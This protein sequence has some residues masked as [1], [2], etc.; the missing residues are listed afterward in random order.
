MATYTISNANSA[1]AATIYLSRG[2]TV[3][4]AANLAGMRLCIPAWNYANGAVL[5]GLGDAR[6][7]IIDGDAS[8]MEEITLKGTVTLEHIELDESLPVKLGSYK[9]ILNDCVINSY[10]TL[11]P[12]GSIEINKAVFTADEPIILS[13]W[14]GSTAGAITGIET[15]TFPE[16]ELNINI[17]GVSGDTMLTN[18]YTND[19]STTTYLIAYD[20]GHDVTLGAGVVLLS[21]WGDLGDL[22]GDTLKTFTGTLTGE[23]GSLLGGAIDLR[24]ATLK[25]VLTLA[26]GARAKVD[27]VTTGAT[28]ICRSGSALSMA[29]TVE[30]DA[31]LKCEAGFMLNQEVSVDALGTLHLAGAQVSAPI[32]LNVTTTLLV[33]EG[34]TFTGGAGIRLINWGGSTEQL[35]TQLS[36]VEAEAAPGITLCSYSNAT[37]AALPW[38]GAAYLQSG[39]QSGILT[40]AAGAILQGDGTSISGTLAGEAGS[41]LTGTIK[42]NATTLKGVL[43]LASGAGVSSSLNVSSGATFVCQAGGSLGAAATVDHGGVLELEPGF[44]LTQNVTVASDGLLKLAGAQVKSTIFL[45]PGAQIEL[46]AATSFSDS[47]AVA[48]IN[49]TGSTA[50]VCEQLAKLGQTPKLT[51][52]TAAGSTVLTTL[53]SGKATY[54]QGGVLNG[55]VT[56]TAGTTLLGNGSSI[57]ATLVGEA[58][59]VLAGTLALD[60]ATLLGTH[61]LDSG[62]TAGALRVGAGATVNARVGAALAS[63]ATVAQGGVLELESGFVLT[64]DVTVQSG[65]TLKL[66]GVQVKATIFLNSGAR[67]ELSAATSFSSTGAIA[68]TNWQGS[69]AELCA[70][71]A[72]LAQQPKLTLATATGSTTLATLPSGKVTYVQGGV[73]NGTVTLTA[74]ATLRGNGSNI[75][76]TLVGEEGSVLAGTLALG[77]ATLQGTHTLASGAKASTLRVVAGATVK[78]QAGAALASAARVENGGVLELE[79]G[80]V[81]TQDVT[82]QSGGTL[83]LEGVQVKATIFLTPDAGL[84]ISAG[85]SFTSTGAI[86]LT[87]WQGGTADVWEKLSGVSFAEGARMHVDSLSGNASLGELPAG[88]TDYVLNCD[89]EQGRTLTLEAGLTLDASGCTIAGTL[90]LRNNTKLVGDVTLTGTASIKA[91]N[92][93]ITHTLILEPGAKLSGSGLSF[94]C[95]TPLVFRNWQGDTADVWAGLSGLSFAGGARVH[96]DSL[97]GNAS[98]G[99]LPAG[100]TGYVLNCDLEQ[101]RT[102]TLEAGQ[103]LDASGG[104]IGGTLDCRAGSIL[105]GDITV[106]DGGVVRLDGTR[107]EGTLTLQPGARI[108]GSDG[109]IF[110]AATPIRLIDWQGDTAEAWSGLSNAVFQ[111]PDATIGIDSVKGDATLSPLPGLECLFKL[112]CDTTAL[113]S[114]DVGSTLLGTTTSF[115]SGVSLT[116]GWSDVNKQLFG[117]DANGNPDFG[118]DPVTGESMY[119][120]IAGASNMLAWWQSTYDTTQ[121]VSLTIPQTAADIYEAMTATWLNLA[122][123]TVFACWWWLTGEAIDVDVDL[124]GVSNQIRYDDQLNET[125]AKDINS[126]YGEYYQFAYDEMSVTEASQ[127]VFTIGVSQQEAV[128]IG[129]NMAKV[130]NSGGV[131]SLGVRWD[132]GATGHV[133]TLWGIGQREDGTLSTLYITDSDDVSTGIKAYK[134]KYV[135]ERLRYEMEGGAYT[136]AYIMSYVTLNAFEDTVNPLVDLS[137]STQATRGGVD[138]VWSSNE[139]T[140]YTLIID[141]E[142]QFTDSSATSYTATLTDGQHSYVFVATDA[143]GNETQKE[144]SFFVDCPPSTAPTVTQLAHQAGTKSGGETRV[145]FSWAAENASSYELTVDGGVVYSG[146][147]TSYSKYL[148]DGEHTYSLRAIGEDGEEGSRQGAD[149]S[150]D[151]TAPV[152]ELGHELIPSATPGMTTVIFSWTADE[153]CSYVLTVDGT[154]HHASDNSFELELPYGRHSY[155]IEA[156]DAFG[157]VSVES[158]RDF[159]LEAAAPTITKLTHQ[160]GTKSD[161]ETKVTFSWA[162]QDATRYEL[163]VDGV[164]VYRGA[165]SSFSKYLG[166]GEHSYSIKAIGEEDKS[167]ISEVTPFTTDA[168]AP[169]V[170]L[171]HELIPSATPG[172]TTV[173]FSWAADEPCSYVLTVDGTPH[174]VSDNSFELELPY[175]R[176]SYFVEATDAFGN[177][178]I[179]SGR[180]FTLEAA[181]LNV[182]KPAFKAAGKGKTKV[183]LSWEGEYG[184]DYTLWVDGKKVA[185]IRGNDK[186]REF[187]RT[188]TVKDGEHVYTIIAAGTGLERSGSFTTDATAPV[189]KLA[190]PTLIKAGEGLLAATFAWSGHEN[191]NVY[192]ITLDKD[193]KPT[194][195]GNDPS[196][197][198]TMADG[199]HSYKVT[200]TD[201]W[202][203]SSTVKGSFSFD[204]TAPTL[205]LNASKLK[206]AKNGSVAATLSW[207]GE[208]GCS[209]TLVLNGKEI[210]MQGKTSY[211]LTLAAGETM[212]YSVIARDKAG[213]ETVSETRTARLDTARPELGELGYSMTPEG[214]TTFIWKA[215]D[216]SGLTFSIKV[217]GK[218]AKDA[219]I[220]YDARTGLYSYTYSA[221]LKGG[222]HRYEVT[223]TDWAG[224]KATLKGADFVTPKLTLSKPKLSKAGEGEVH[225]LFSWKGD[226]NARYTLMVDSQAVEGGITEGKK[227]AYSYSGTFSDGTHSYRVTGVDAAG[228]YTVA[229]GSFSFD[230]TAPGIILGALFGEVDKKGKVKATLNWSGEDGVSYSIKLGKKSVYS[231]KGV[232]RSYTFETGTHTLSITAKDKAGNTYTSTERLKVAV[233]NG[234]AVLTW[235]GAEQ[236]LPSMAQAEELSWH[237]ADTAGIGPAA[238]GYSFTLTEARQLRVA[239]DGLEA[240]ATVL[241]RRE[242]GVGSIELA[243]HAATGLDRELSLSAGS[244]SLQVLGT[245]TGELGDYALDLELLKKNSKQSFGQA[246]LAVNQA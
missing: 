181:K 133:V 132:A 204:A 225:A 236:D 60:S 195:C 179:E 227:G 1:A 211:K 125:V 54:V 111:H 242:G 57:S 137:V 94:S 13:E 206:Q 175:G 45:N 76:A 46:S 28:L 83:K 48:L 139:K 86:A 113:L 74:G 230:A 6:P 58:G 116:E 39:A 77:S 68:L 226:S 12:G 176:H 177:A 244:Y 153:P 246:V 81:L 140:T 72:T 107:V 41:L 149:F 84:E 10:L 102:L 144:D 173:I 29:T 222:K 42:L 124:L 127:L 95:E 131:I 198:L 178:C 202:G 216:E 112:N 166:D 85:T 189:L 234:E 233:V 8:T 70:Q 37:L 19:Q 91:S 157:N 162:A 32:N 170:E 214:A 171:R 205:T 161:G 79:P 31:T 147:A 55:T 194:Y 43:T 33:E 241:L 2:Y 14:S 128:T 217:D 110:T 134:V 172:M 190:Q 38:E 143:A 197:T 36:H 69:T 24:Y 15:A 52:V 62:A 174:H 239:L 44:V 188:V 145:S 90:D 27:S 56:L 201:A 18:L 101:G 235:L 148:A 49:W 208:S 75:T 221:A 228:D 109:A 150:T 100:V 169:V 122:G 16:N 82:L 22:L 115:A 47:A 7:I 80:F 104:T 20:N 245:G 67:I 229:E 53:P 196:P 165:A 99:E 51:L 203:N 5:R 231:G 123:N 4:L 88:V 120:W 218:A 142:L 183:T 156:T 136:G 9:L 117:Y 71:L 199:K 163:T 118:N 184:A 66:A 17:A 185:T 87:N 210:G 25:G 141:G 119:C 232:T 65:G 243:A 89:L 59:S 151:A 154:P 93:T 98:L 223:A 146:K 220:S 130:F 182:G 121:Y 180:D 23:K 105:K 21:Y 35:C 11:T 219:A 96:V 40:L 103:T 64:Q 61:T 97:S 63:A 207:K 224:N 160:E 26:S 209:Y 187:S 240:D 3:E 155:F 186:T 213:N 106:A 215:T 167:T 50:E 238:G 138:F 92:S 34:T 152:V 212:P 78:C 193:E 164:V 73:L 114:I 237:G 158:G 129:N 168:T 192:T 126:G 30:Y 135:A 108:E 191:G 159:T 200:A